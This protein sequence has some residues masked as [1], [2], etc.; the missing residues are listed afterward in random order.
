MKRKKEEIFAYVRDEILRSS[1]K[2]VSTEQ[3]AEA[4]GLQ[5][6]NVSSALNALVKEGRLI[7]SKNRPVVY[8][9]PVAN[10]DSQS[11]HFDDLVGADTV[12][13]Q[14][15]AAAQAYLLYPHHMGILLLVCED[16]TVSWLFARR[17][18]A[19]ARA[20][21]VIPAGSHFTHI[22]CSLQEP[23][24]KAV[25]EHA[26]GRQGMIYVDHTEL[27]SPI[28]FSRLRVEASES[29]GQFWVMAVERVRD[30]AEGCIVISLPSISAFGMKD[31][32]LLAARMIAREAKQAGCNLQI[33]REAFLV[34]VLY[35]EKAKLA[36]LGQDVRYACAM[37]YRRI[38]GQ[39]DQELHVVQ[40][41]LSPAVREYAIENRQKI[42]EMIPM[43]SSDV[44]L[45]DHEKG[46]LGYD[47]LHNDLY[48]MV[49]KEEKAE[50]EAN[51]S[52]S[53]ELAKIVDPRL[54]Q[55]V[56]VWLEETGQKLS[57]SFAPDVFYGICLHLNAYA[58]HPFQPSV[59][60][61]EKIHEI[62]DDH[63]AEYACAFSLAR[64]LYDEL[65]LE[66]N[67][68]EIAALSQYLFTKRQGEH[69]PALLYCFHGSG[70]AKALAEA[71]NALT[72]LHNAYGFDMDLDKDPGQ[73]GRQLGDLVTQ[74]NNGAGIVAIYDMGSFQ[75]M[76]ET[77]SARM[78]IPIRC[79]YMP[80]TLWGLD[81]AR[82]CAR[83]ESADDVYHSF[84]LEN[85]EWRSDPEKK[86]P[87]I[88]TLCQTGEG[89]AMEL[90]RYIDQYSHLGIPAIAMSVDNREHL[91]RRV[92]MLQRTSRIHAFVGTF[93]PHMF[94]I[95]FIPVSR[96]FANPREV[97]D[98]VLTFAP[99]RTSGKSY[100]QV[101]EFLQEEFHYTSIP[102]L[103]EL[104]PGVVDALRRDYDLNDQQEDGIFI[105]IA[106]AI[107][108]I[109][110]GK[111]SPLVEKGQKD[112]V[113]RACREDL[114][115][116]ARIVRRLE[117]G[118]HM[119]FADDDL[120]TLV[121]MLRHIS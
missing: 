79:I 89:G 57:R 55:I 36:M 96:I 87:V 77:L 95:P 45:F 92:E 37:A 46:F 113:W 12:L 70:A 51:H 39:K 105:H 4:L 120:V 35:E 99:V 50:R 2:G 65:G 22:D 61:D 25:M 33:S 7:K 121:I 115:N 42:R 82:M 110:A 47:E 60:S 18:E 30:Q 21:Q 16:I 13:A 49:Q 10:Q 48:Q 94:G 67:T 86:Q 9:L 103:K 91:A 76:L 5:R 54:I 63:A 98:Q 117:K 107:E 41:D 73:A 24:A 43:V 85:R 100:D 29:T 104:L 28:E 88:V 17:M 84:M 15:I 62:V 90:K 75:T 20:K 19:F 118:F 83:Q 1:T 27:L 56:S 112:K 71:T 81:L 109:L 64:I 72:H 26:Q 58:S 114:N 101:Y 32:I 53:D 40:E 11:S 68:D 80:V 14:A 59:L 44:L 116:V 119:V 78:H 69:H 74:I 108:R 97:L 102:R 66:L 52:D 8:Q 111:P 23:T 93:N 31:R 38:V 6:S 106:C 34:I 3:T